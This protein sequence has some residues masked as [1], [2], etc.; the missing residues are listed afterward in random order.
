[1]GLPIRDVWGIVLAG[2]EGTRLLPLTSYLTGGSRPKQFCVMS[3]SRTLLGQ[4][5]ARIAPL[6]VPER[7]VVVGNRDHAGH[8]RRD[9]PGAVPHALLQPSNKGTGPGILWP[10]HWVSWRDPEAI[11]AVFPSDHFILQERSFLGYVAQAVRVVRQCR[12]LVLL[13]GMDPDSPEEGYGWIEPGGPVAEAPGCFRVR[14]FCEKPKAE[15]ARAFFRAGFLW[16]TLVMVARVE[17]LKALGRKFLPDVDARLARVK[18]FAASEHEAWALRQ[19]YALMRAASFSREV[20]ERGVESLAVLPVYGVL[21]SDWGTPDR[22]LRTLTRINA[23]PPWLEEW[24]ERSA[25]KAGSPSAE[26]REGRGAR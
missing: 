24:L 10:A 19:A 14:R 7:T 2:G 22:V 21:W 13:L 20:L 25:P 26:T 1:M 15:G 9:V 8:L 11:V 23:S 17:A 5:L 12:E 18:G 4:T 3:G 6:V 16:N